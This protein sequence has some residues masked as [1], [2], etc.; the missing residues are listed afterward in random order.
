L[1]NGTQTTPP[2]SSDSLFT[3]FSNWANQNKTLM[4]SATQLVGGALKGASEQSMWNQKM[5]LQ[6]AQFNR[7]N[8]VG[9]FAPGIIQKATS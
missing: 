8:S 3:R 4:N 7:A 9:T 6:T 1:A 5:A 2:E